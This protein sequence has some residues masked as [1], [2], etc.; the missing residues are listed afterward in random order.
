[1]ESK[2]SKQMKKLAQKNAICDECSQNVYYQGAW[3]SVK[4]GLFLCQD[5]AAIHRGLGTHISFV[6]SVSLD[7]WNRE[8][9]QT[10]MQAKKKNLNSKLE[11]V[12]HLGLKPRPNTEQRLKRQFIKNKHV[13]KLYFQESSLESDEEDETPEETGSE[14]PHEISKENA[15]PFIQIG[16][17]EN[18]NLLETEDFDICVDPFATKPVDSP[19]DIQMKK[20]P[21]DIID[22]IP[23]K[24]DPLK[25]IKSQNENAIGTQATEIEASKD[26]AISDIMRMF[27]HRPTH[28]RWCHRNDL[29]QQSTTQFMN[30]NVQYAR[31]KY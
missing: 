21:L 10:F 11:A 27:Q 2:Y 31:F 25:P 17:F 30:Q 9:Y 22:T 19:V 18:V 1:M 16:D 29:M 14:E 28:Q 15:E 3:T 7:K 6:K 24:G 26:D 12:L 13:R 8:L 5:C 4:L 23:F 20:E